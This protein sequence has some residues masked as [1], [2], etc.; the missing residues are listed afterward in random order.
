VKVVTT[1]TLT[2]YAIII[3]DIVTF[4]I[5]Y[6]VVTIGCSYIRCGSDD[7]CLITTTTTTASTTYTMMVSIISHTCLLPLECLQ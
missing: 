1:D 6:R 2:A 4:V 7:G 3:D 5:R